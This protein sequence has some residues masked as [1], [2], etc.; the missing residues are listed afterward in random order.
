M[1]H[2]HRWRAQRLY[3]NPQD[4]TCMGVCAG[5]ADYFGWNITTTRVLVIIALLWFSVLT[6]MV[7]LALG[8]ILPIRPDALCDG[9]TDA[10]YRRSTRRPAGENF[11]DARHH[12]AELDMRLQRMEGYV[13]SN[14]YDLDRQF[15][16]LEN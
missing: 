7:Y 5:M 16:D 14:R 6:V 1:R 13:T 2:N 10:A 11:Y 15:R 8:F 3:R 9:D 4:G 12:F